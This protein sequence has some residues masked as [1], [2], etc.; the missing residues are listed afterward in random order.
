MAIATIS[1]NLCWEDVLVV[2]SCLHERDMTV[3]TISLSVLCENR[4]GGRR[5]LPVFGR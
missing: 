2:E 3:A 4:G 1:V 5:T